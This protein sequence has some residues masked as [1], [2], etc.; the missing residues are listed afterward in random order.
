MVSACRVLI[1]DHHTLLGCDGLILFAAFTERLF[2]R[3]RTSAGPCNKACDCL[4]HGDP[5]NRTLLPI[6]WLACLATLS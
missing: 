4:S 6:G 2:S 5:V 1:L 3:C